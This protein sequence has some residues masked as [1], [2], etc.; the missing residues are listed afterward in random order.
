[1]TARFVWSAEASY[2]GWGQ[3]AWHRLQGGS[4]LVRRRCCR[5]RW[6]RG[7]LCCV[8]TARKELEK[9]VRRVAGR[10]TRRRDAGGGGPRSDERPRRES[11]NND[12]TSVAR[13]TDSKTRGRHTAFC[14]MGPPADVSTQCPQPISPGA[15]SAAKTISASPGRLRGK[16]TVVCM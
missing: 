15:R 10:A 7:L 12:K 11:G 3:A 4:W 16:S 5:S 8:T 9:C 6:S 2:A 1:M 14:S 13:H